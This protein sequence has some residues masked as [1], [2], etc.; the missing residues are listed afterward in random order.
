MVPGDSPIIGARPY[1]PQLFVLGF[2]F[3]THLKYSLV[4]RLSPEWY[5][6]SV[7]NHHDL[8]NA[9]AGTLLS[10]EATPP[11]K[12]PKLFKAYLQALMVR[13]KD[14]TS[15]RSVEKHSLFDDVKTST[16]WFSRK[17]V[18]LFV[19]PETRVGREITCSSSLLRHAFA[20]L[21]TNAIEASCR[22]PVV[23]KYAEYDNYTSVV[24]NDAGCG[25][26]RLDTVRCTWFGWSKKEHGLGLGLGAAKWILSKYCGADLKIYS[27]LGV[28]TT[29]VCSF[30]L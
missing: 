18:L 25:M 22:L 2:Q 26:S 28:G 6:A 30:P 17:E 3:L 21:L 29:V 16:D 27:T 23:V 14:S 8:S 7:V 1:L 4:F 12:R 9:V 20:V 13:I 15:T 11:R 19:E 5:F 24:I 10:M